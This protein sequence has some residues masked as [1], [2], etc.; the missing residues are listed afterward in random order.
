MR[1]HNESTTRLLIGLTLVTLTL[2]CNNAQRDADHAQAEG[3]QG[4][5]GD[6][7]DHDKKVGEGGDH[8]GH[9][10]NETYDVALLGRLK[11]RR[12]EHKV[13]ILECDQCRYEVG[14][15]QLGGALLKGPKGK[16][17]L[18]RT[19]P[20]ARGARRSKVR[21]TGEVR[22]DEKRVVHISPRVGGVARRVFVT[23][24]DLVKAGAALVEMDSLSLGRLRSSYLQARARLALARKDH[25]REKRLYKEQISSAKEKL[26]TETALQQAKIAL[27]AARDQL[28][29]IGVSTPALGRLDGQPSGRGGRMTL[30]APRAGRIVAKHVVPGERLTPDKEVLTVADLSEVWVWANVYERD[31]A[32]LL[33]A[34]AAGR[35]GAEVK[36]AA[37]RDRSFVGTVDYIGATMEEATRTVKVRVVVPNKKGLLRP[38]M[39]AEVTVALKQAGQ[40]IFAPSEA[41]VSD[42]ASRFVFVKISPWR[43]LRRDVRTGGTFEGKVEIASGLKAGEEIVVHGAFMLKSDVLREKMGAGCAD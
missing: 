24:G 27:K 37:F 15:V 9:E 19:A 26:S 20:A 17:G 31:L 30:R 1:R 36:V 4:G 38:G 10:H 18:I 11:S 5:H 32:R 33:A 8:A 23:T 2:S 29:L 21:L 7:D 14:A 3:A 16:G 43:F 39:F 34:K 25:E 40:A 41:V 6:H 28:R 22:F 12:C 35:L 13:G 42:G